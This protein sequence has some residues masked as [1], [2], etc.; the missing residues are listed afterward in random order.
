MWT[1][2]SDMEAAPIPDDVLNFK[3]E[4]ESQ[5]ITV[6]EK[7]VKKLQDEKDKLLET[8]REDK[9]DKLHAPKKEEKPKADDDLGTSDPPPHVPKSP[10]AEKEKSPDAEKKLLQEE[11]R[12]RGIRF[13]HNS[14][15][16]RLQ[17]LLKENK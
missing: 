10:S 11:C 4:A 17:E 3:K 5:R 9:I 15:I 2:Y 7:E 12:K 8:L 14:G 6:L 1:P 13:A 16:P